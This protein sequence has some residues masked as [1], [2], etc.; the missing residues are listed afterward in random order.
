[1]FWTLNVNGSPFESWA[2]GLKEYGCPAIADVTG[3]PL[4]TGGLFVPARTVMEK[5]ASEALAAPS[6]TVITMLEMDPAEVGVPL[7]LPFRLLN[8]AHAGL[9][10]ILKLSACP[11]GSEAVGR[12]T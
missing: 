5:G 7:S 10:A 9:F 6:D 12:K 1:L 3:A 4:I 2:V 8:L 11:S